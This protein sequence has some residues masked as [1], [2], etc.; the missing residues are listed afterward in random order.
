MTG[1][2]EASVL[3]ALLEAI[4]DLEGY[5]FR[6]MQL[7]ELTPMWQSKANIYILRHEMEPDELEENSYPAIDTLINLWR[8]AQELGAEFDPSYREYLAYLD[9]AKISAYIEKQG[10]CCLNCGLSSALGVGPLTFETGKIYQGVTC[11]NCKSSWVDV[12]RLSE[13]VLGNQ[14][15]KD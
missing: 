4:A 7:D 11:H 2:L 14:D 1:D 5:V 15:R 9:K 8:L 6:E 10:E 3:K 13:V 12:Y